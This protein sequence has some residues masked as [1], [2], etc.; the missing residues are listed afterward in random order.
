MNV[1]PAICTVTPASVTHDMTAVNPSDQGIEMAS[2][3]RSRSECA[4]ST[5]K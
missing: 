2:P 5:R 1:I 3:N 4:Q